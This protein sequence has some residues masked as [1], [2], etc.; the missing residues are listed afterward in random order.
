MRYAILESPISHIA[1]RK[2]MFVEKSLG[3]VIGSKVL[4]YD[5]LDSTN[6][7]VAELFAENCPDGTVV[8]SDFQTKGRGQQ[9]NGWESERGKN[10]TFSIGF[11]PAF[12]K[13]EEQFLLSKAVSLGVTDF[14][15][16]LGL[17]A[18]IK[19][20]N[21]IYIGDK[22]VTGILI[23]HSVTGALIDSS[24]VGIGLNL[25]QTTF[26]SNAP[27]PSSVAIELGQEFDREKALVDLMVCLE[28]RYL[29]LKLADK[30]MLEHSYFNRLYR[31]NGFFPYESNGQRFNAR[32]VGIKNTGELVLEDEKKKQRQ[33]AFK[34][35]SF[36]LP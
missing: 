27:N 13:V 18:R 32:I 8:M 16:Q 26:V 1:Y 36:I 21:D 31:L 33:F 29:S 5:E 28:K 22:K 14:L 24:I 34:E 2:N 7:K 30:T 25:N 20:P 12:I 19:W 17:D 3:Q 11:Y 10:L 6:N 23:E 35:V 9:N 15:I 4:W